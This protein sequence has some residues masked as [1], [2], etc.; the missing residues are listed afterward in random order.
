MSSQSA[1]PDEEK[2]FVVGVIQLANLFTRRLAPLFK[3][4]RITPQ[5]WGVLT[6]L[7]D[8]ERPATLVGIARRLLVSKQNMTGMIARLE[9][10]ALISRGDDPN[11]LRSSRVQ[12]TRRGRQLID[13]LTPAY[14]DWLDQAI[15][16]LDEDEQRALV[17]GVARLIDKLADE[18]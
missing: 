7:S 3:Q 1:T 9:E 14:R 4:A 12:L 17:S 8:Q 5:Q 6:A 13:K 2:D 15:S 18:E 11:D 10:L 16:D